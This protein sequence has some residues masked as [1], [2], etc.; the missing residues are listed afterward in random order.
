[1][2]GRRFNLSG[3]EIGI[4][5]AG[6]FVIILV[7]GVVRHFYVAEPPEQVVS[8]AG[9]P[10]DPPPG[11]MPIGVTPLRYV[12]DFTIIPA[13]THFSGT[14]TIEVSIDFR[15]DYIWLH[16]RGIS[17]SQAMLRKPDGK[18]VDIIYEQVNDEGVAKVTFPKSVKPGTYMVQLEYSAAF[19]EAMDGLYTM[20][21][22][23]HTYAFSQLQPIDA[24]RVF[25][26]FDE[27]RFKTPYEVSITAPV[28][29]VVITNGAEIDM[30][31]VGTDQALH[32]FEA[33]ESISPGLLSFSVGPFEVIGGGDLP[34][35]ELRPQA[36]P[37]RGITLPGRSE[38]MKPMLEATRPML[39]A[40]EIYFGQPYPYSKLDLV[41]I[42]GFIWA[43]MESPGA[44]NYGESYIL[45]DDSTTASDYLE[46]VDTHAHELAHQW[47]GNLV[48]PVWWD[49]VWLSESFAS[50][51]S[52]KVVEEWDASLGADDL[53]KR[54]AR[55]G[56]D[57]DANPLVGIVRQ[58]VDGF[59][60]IMT[61]FSDLAYYKGGG[62]LEMVEAYVGEQNFREGVAMYMKRHEDGV[63]TLD[64]F[65][66]AVSVGSRHPE[67]EGTFRSFLSQP[68]IPVVEAS[69]DCS[70]TIK[71]VTFLQ[72]RYYPIDTGAQDEM[73]WDIP[74]C[75]RT[76]EGRA[77]HLLKD[78]SETLN[79]GKTC[80]TLL[81]PN[82]A[83]SG[84]YL[85]FLDEGTRSDLLKNLKSLTPIE[86]ESMAFNLGH[87][88]RSDRI[89][90]EEFF[91]I[92]EGLLALKRY[93]TDIELIDTLLDL[94]PVAGE[95]KGELHAKIN[96]LL[97]S[98]ARQLGFNPRKDEAIGRS[99]LRDRLINVLVV[100]TNDLVMQ[101]RLQGIMLRE[102][103]N[104]D[105]GLKDGPKVFGHDRG[106][107]MLTMAVKHD[108]RAVT[109]DL[110]RLVAAGNLQANEDTIL[111][112]LA[113]TPSQE[114]GKD[115][116]NKVL[117][118][119]SISDTA[120]GALGGYLALNPQQASAFWT[121]LGE[122]DNLE[123][124]L[125]RMPESFRYEVAN[126]GARICDAEA[127]AS[128]VAALESN[129]DLLPGGEE[130][131]AQALQSIDQCLALKVAKGPELAAYLD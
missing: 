124:Y 9:Y 82:D 34:A 42:P 126:L 44:I 59:D 99:L 18:V 78:K 66:S 81:M 21:R 127:R 19:S 55:I 112:A 50:W 41:A 45:V 6:L 64:D 48:T 69:L 56:M 10:V 101:K 14:S 105:R 65:V 26:G 61:S 88:Y 72:S 119:S 7:I 92:A 37:L 43:G 30:M 103:I 17:V 13:E 98:R 130:P 97:S 60:D 47:F 113:A 128:F 118:S 8:E 32:I 121:W 5:I 23:G 115:I 22:D 91:Q 90:T 96:E 120:A 70:A 52:G 108:R 3:N 73:F 15:T 12:L 63:A 75:Y 114:L 71:Q 79:L 1:M 100:G 40:L 129:L 111:M 116:R 94:E 122:D 36:I 123:D 2:A 80:P 62:V 4:L 95:A 67:A 86:S 131:Y 46:I 58:E 27:P 54:G 76:D 39:E 38:N 68:G 74:V 102:G 77:C 29:D 53:I 85:W 89:S 107:V 109:K 93:Q 83:S 57:E 11:P 31:P 84:Y 35:T 16:G 87:W 125:D 49:D 28:D 33:T 20:E 51:I 25:P 104:L 110:M 24:R 106:G 117:L